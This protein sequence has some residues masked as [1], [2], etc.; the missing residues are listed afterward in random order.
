MK[1]RIGLLWAVVW[2]VLLILYAARRVMA[3]AIIEDSRTGSLTISYRESNDGNEP[4]QG[5]VFSVLRVAI[6]EQVVGDLS[7]S[8]GYRSLLFDSKK[9][10]IS[11]GASTKADS[12]EAAALSAYKSGSVSEGLSVAV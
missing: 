8:L 3:S 9:K 10:A 12:I 2:P 4:V 7:V 6:P 5:A 11:I 1:R